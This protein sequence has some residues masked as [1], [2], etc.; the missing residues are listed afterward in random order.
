MGYDSLHM[1]NGISDKGMGGSQD[2]RRLVKGQNHLM[3]VTEKSSPNERGRLFPCQTRLQKMGQVYRWDLISVCRLD[4][5]FVS[6]E[7]VIEKVK[8]LLDSESCNFRLV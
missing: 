2:G 7:E 4:W 8:V 5:E 3:E 6:R 1:D